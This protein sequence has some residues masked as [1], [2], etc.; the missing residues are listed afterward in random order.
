MR[1]DSKEKH[2]ESIKEFEAIV[3]NYPNPKY[4]VQFLLFIASY[5]KDLGEYQN[6]IAIFERIVRNYPHSSLT[7]I[8]QCAIGII[9]EEKLKDNDRAKAAYLKVLSNYPQS[10]EAEEATAGLGRLTR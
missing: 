10:P 4:D 9:Y 7:S 8:A 3:N 5:Y 1:E 2:M 6:A